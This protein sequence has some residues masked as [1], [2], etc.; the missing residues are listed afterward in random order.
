MTDLA[1]PVDIVVHEGMDAVRAALDAGLAGVV[2]A[3]RASGWL[4]PRSAYRPQLWVVVAGEEPV[5]AVL[6]TGR[7]ATAATTLVEPWWTSDSALGAMLDRVVGAARARRDVAVKWRTAGEVPAAAI[8]AGFVPLRAPHGAV[9]TESTRGAVR[10]LV[11]MPHEEPGYY[12]QT[13]LFTCGAV[14]ALMA[15][16]L[17]GAGGFTGDADDRDR[18]LEYWRRASN[19]PACEPVGLAVATAEHLGHGGDLRRVEVALDADG[20]VL[21]ED[22][23][24]FDLSFRTEL[25]TESR[26]RAADLGIPISS[27]RVTVA[28]IARRVAGGE[29]ALLLIDEEPMHGEHGPHWVL[30]HAS[31]GV[32][33]VVIEDPWINRDTGET[34]VD[35][36][37]LP[38]RAAD[39]D[40]L[41]RWS[42][43]GYRGVV[44]LG[45]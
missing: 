13:T 32:D 16:G 17:R 30:A 23:R 28:E 45:R 39:L 27:E 34:W 18:E 29:L 24:G 7:P 41:V 8:D 20:P 21:V 11:E 4:A 33:V 44:F 15:A 6:T 37:E 22:Y 9:G 19:F 5:A 25:Q 31:D 43:T 2:G 12:A 10:W 35:T 1:V 3:D 36:H 26:R 40:R 42:A 38:V 14:A